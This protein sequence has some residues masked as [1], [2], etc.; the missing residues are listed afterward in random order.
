MITSSDEIYFK[1]SDLPLGFYLVEIM[2][3]GNHKLLRKLIIN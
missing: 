2:L 3:D 1:T